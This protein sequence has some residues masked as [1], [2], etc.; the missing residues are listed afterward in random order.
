MSESELL[1]EVKGTAAWITL[2]REYRRNAISIEMIDLFNEH[3][4][5]AAA[6]DTVR[7]VCITGV[8]DKAF[9]TGADLL[10]AFGQDD[11]SAG[12]KKYANLL[13]KMNAFPKPIVARLNGHCLAGAMGLM[14]SCDIVYAREGI[15]IGTPEVKVGLF[16]MMIGAL[17]F[18][19]AVRKKAL[20]MI[21][22]ARMYTPEQAEEMGLVT[23][24]FPADQLD[25]ET[26]KV[27]AE[28]GA[29]GPVAIAF[30]REA[31]AKAQEMP[32]DDA[33]DYLCDKLGQVLKTEDATEGLT[34]FMEKRKPE[35]KGR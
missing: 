21:Y 12:P 26:E 28:I 27:L 22:T 15:K 3:L 7:S 19:N 14:L 11:P 1:Y 34:A 30:G 4:D 16:P 18:R 33:L 9:C 20:E 8:G 24:V 2:N 35:W 5:N 23:R 31:L 17:I 10:A 32:L 6:D 25:V 29:Q 13:K